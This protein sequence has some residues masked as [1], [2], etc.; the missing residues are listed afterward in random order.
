MKRKKEILICLIL[1]AAVVF[2]FTF[3]TALTIY[4]DE[5]AAE[6][7]SEETPDTPLQGFVVLDGKTYY[8]HENGEMA[9]GLT[10]IDNNTYYF[11][12]TTGVMLTGL[13]T[14]SG[15]T[16]Y[17]G[18][19]GK[20][21][22]G[23]KTINGSKY[24]FKKGKALKNGLYKISGNACTFS[25]KGVLVRKVYGNRK[26]VC[27]TYDD[28][29]SSNTK[30]ILSTL[31][32][33]G[34]LATFFVVGNRI[35]TYSDSFKAVVKAGNQIGNHSWSHPYYNT[36]SSSAISSQISRCNSKAASYG[37][38]VKVCRT[39]G[40]FV[41]S[42]INSAVGMPVI[43]WSIDT[44]DWKTQSSDSTYNAVMNNVRD[45][46][47]ILMHDLYSATA[48]ASTRIIPALVKKGYQLVTIDEMAMIKGV[49]LKPG[50]VY[51]SFR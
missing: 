27:L 14:I 30:L 11:G 16:Y 19:D 45:G 39:P 42:S 5:P 28:G 51:T 40:G 4:A 8:Y 44:L 49:K 2:T 20:A 38:S 48:N 25:K 36:M 21:Q 9:K 18:S 50:K 47:I 37:A 7:P 15:S 1:S 46:D 35:S 17:F 10:V 13:R 12:K 6:A 32:K 34:G 24:Y 43:L 3:S 33:N 22:S 26:A 31:K 29:P 23:W 41:S